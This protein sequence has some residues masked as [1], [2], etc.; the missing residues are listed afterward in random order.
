[1]RGGFS[2]TLQFVYTRGTGEDDVTERGIS[3]MIFR[4]DELVGSEKKVTFNM[5]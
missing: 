5:S 1:L 2:L 3:K 4:G